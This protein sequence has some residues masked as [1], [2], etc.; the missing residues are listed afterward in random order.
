[1][2]ALP[3]LCRDVLRTRDF[4]DKATGAP[5][6]IGQTG[7]AGSTPD[8]H[9]DASGNLFGSK[10]GGRGVN[11]LISIDKTTGGGTVIGAIGFAGVS[12]LASYVHGFV[13]FANRDVE[14]DGQVDSEG[15]IHANDD[16]EFG[17]GNPSTHTGDLTAVDEI[18]ISKDITI[19][20]DARA[21]DDVDNSGTITGNVQEEA[22]IVPI[23]LPEL[24]FTAG[25]DDVEVPEG[26]SLTLAPGS[27]GKVEVEDGGTLFLSSGSYFVEELDVESSSILSIDISGGAVSINVTVDL[28]FEDESKVEIGPSELTTS[29]IFNQAGTKNVHIGKGASVL[30]TINAPLAKVELESDSRFKGSICAREIEVEKDVTF[31]HHSSST[32]L[33]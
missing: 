23:P 25:G 9:F 17:T 19:V 15:N 11:N 31:R 16:I 27:Y 21:A 20:G 4:V 29:V 2:L 7:I 18:D 24:D 32:P 28:D 30:G 14:I 12:G 6:F 3:S 8:I 10:G 5:T 26:G 13:L 1:M 33:R 22:V